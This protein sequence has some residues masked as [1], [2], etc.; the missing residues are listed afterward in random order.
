MNRRVNKNGS[1]E[2]LSLI[3][4]CLNEDFAIM[5][6]L[7]TLQLRNNCIENLSSQFAKLNKKIYDLFYCIRF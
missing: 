4:P 3:N 2:T 6:Q 5:A 1:V 7:K